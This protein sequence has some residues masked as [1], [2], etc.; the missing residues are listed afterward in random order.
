MKIGDTFETFNNIWTISDI[1]NENVLLTR[2]DDESGLI[3]TL[4]T[5]K[6]YIKN[7]CR[8]T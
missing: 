3:A 4:F 5:T 1:F 2:H 7:Y 6:H 8:G